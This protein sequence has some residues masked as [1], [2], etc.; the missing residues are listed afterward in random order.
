M[1]TSAGTNNPVPQGEPLNLAAI[2]QQFKAM[3]D[4]IVQLEAQ[5]QAG[6]GTPEAKA[7]EGTA[8]KERKRVKLSAPKEFNGQQAALAGFL[9]QMQTYFDFYKDQFASEYEKVTYA[10]TRLTDKALTWYEPILKDHYEN[11]DEASDFTKK[12]LN[13][14]TEFTKAL[15][16]VFGEKDETRRA[17]ERLTHLRQTKSASAYA[18]LFKQDAL[19][20]NI[21]DDGLMQLF[22]NGLKDR[23]KDELYKEDRPDSID[24]YMD[25]AI[26]ID[27]RQFQREQ[28]K[29]GKTPSFVPLKSD[30]NN[31]KRRTWGTHLS[32]TTHSGPMEIDAAQ[33]NQGKRDFS[34]V[35][36]FNCG[37]KGH[38]KRDC[39]SPKQLKWEKA[40]AAAIEGAR[41]VETASIDYD[42][43]DL[44]AAIERA[45]D[46]DPEGQWCTTDG[47]DHMTSYIRQNNQE[48][49]TEAEQAALLT[50]LQ[51]FNSLDEEEPTREDAPTDYSQ[52]LG[53]GSGPSGRPG[54][55]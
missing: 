20:S 7:G 40:E 43:S 8:P 6:T 14:Y 33:A 1:S 52:D 32:G 49:P 15:S 12:V 2:Q 26:R 9:I 27:D 38:M 5:L 17:Q 51:D 35:K 16:R 25:K 47:P 46:A 53:N 44:E 21:N 3:Q 24:A 23:V 54:R 29:K 42:Q 37:K 36:C 41:V 22:Y 48:E 19:R 39:R 28:E 50:W 45:L 34:Q 31:K 30:T 10:G 11:G 55:N 4:R 13:S 18:A